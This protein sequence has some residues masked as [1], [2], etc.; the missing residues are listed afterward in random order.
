MTVAA[1][2]AVHALAKQVCAHILRP[3]GATLECLRSRHASPWLGYLRA[4]CFIELTAHK[5]EGTF[6][7]PF[8]Q[9]TAAEILGRDRASIQYGIRKWGLR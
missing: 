8:S 7:R 3:H 1:P 6:S 9:D 5:I 4:R 2:R